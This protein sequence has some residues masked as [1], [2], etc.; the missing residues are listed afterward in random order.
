MGKKRKPRSECSPDEL[1]RRRE[2]TKRARKKL[3]DRRIAE[4]RCRYCGQKKPQRDRRHR[5]T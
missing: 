4:G 2:Q 3:I 5:E 1:R